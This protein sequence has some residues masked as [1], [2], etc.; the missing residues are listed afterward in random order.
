MA[1]TR[2]NW[3]PAFLSL[4][5]PGWGQ[6]EQQRTRAGRVFLG[7]AG[8]ALLLGAYAPMLGLSSALLWIELAIV[9]LWAT[10]DALLHRQLSNARNI[11]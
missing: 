2:L 1:S 10:L 5:V 7:W 9:T 8:L 11:A 4:L 3:N 6:F